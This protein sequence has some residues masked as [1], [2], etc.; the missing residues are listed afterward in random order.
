MT[1][2]QIAAAELVDAINIHF[3]AL[4]PH[5][6]TVLVPLSLNLAEANIREAKAQLHCNGS[7]VPPA[8]SPPPPRGLAFRVIDGGRCG[9]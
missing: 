1:A 8:P 5:L 4:P 7:S 3:S 9:H 6:Q 2:L